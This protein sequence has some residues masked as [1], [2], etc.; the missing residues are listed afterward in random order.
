MPRV[1]D[2]PNLVIMRKRSVKCEK[3]AQSVGVMR[4][5]LVN[6]TRSL[7]MMLELRRMNFR[8]FVV[9]RRLVGFSRAKCW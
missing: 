9:L 1:G 7:L 4:Q 8:D 3:G 6:H 2:Y 5:S